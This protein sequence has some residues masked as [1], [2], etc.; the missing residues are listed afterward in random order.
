MFKAAFPWASLHDEEI[1]KK[2]IKSLPETG[3]EEIAGNVWIPAELGE[4]CPTNDAF[5]YCSFIHSSDRLLIHSS[6]YLFYTRLF[7]QS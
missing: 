1:E 5:C 6:L 2:Y 7:L 4:H 3:D